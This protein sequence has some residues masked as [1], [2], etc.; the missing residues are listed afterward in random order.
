MDFIYTI[1]IT[2]GIVFFVALI[3]VSVQWSDESKQ[4]NNIK[5]D[6]YLEKA[7][8]Q[9]Q[10]NGFSINRSV[11]LNKLIG[12]ESIKAYALHFDVNNKKIAITNAE[13]KTCYITGFDS[14]MSYELLKNK[15]QEKSGNFGDALVGGFLFG[16]TG[17]IIGASSNSTISEKITS[18]QL[19][20][21][22]NDLSNSLVQFNLI[23]DSTGVN[24]TN[25]KVKEIYNQINELISCLEYVKYN[26]KNAETKTS[27]N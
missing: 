16:T 7:E 13:T 1:A 14:L 21:K 3:I 25:K 2:I 18:L 20:I 15:N 12:V 11:F 26:Q 27:N 9:L 5:S 19:L 8:T 24:E 6:N 22:I 10:E 17:A 23:N 4:I